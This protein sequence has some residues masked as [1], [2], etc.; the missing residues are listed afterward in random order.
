MASR[1]CG[2]ITPAS[3]S[4]SHRPRPHVS[5]RGT[6]YWTLSLPDHPGEPVPLFTRNIS[7]SANMLF[8]SKPNASICR[9]QP[10]GYTLTLCTLRHYVGCLLLLQGQLPGWGH[11]TPLRA[12]YICILVEQPHNINDGKEKTG[13]PTSNCVGPLPCI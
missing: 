13:G 5:W 8:Q 6:Y 7:L 12:C 10:P 4:P 9:F 1:G 11:R 3:V 2:H